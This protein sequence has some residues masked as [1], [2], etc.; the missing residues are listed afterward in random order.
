M[1]RDAEMTLL[2]VYYSY[3]N[4]YATQYSSFC[5]NY[6]WCFQSIKHILCPIF[7]LRDFVTKWIYDRFFEDTS[8]ALNRANLPYQIDGLGLRLEP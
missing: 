1:T 6:T 7:S 3:N 5:Y 4:T 2:D 8:M